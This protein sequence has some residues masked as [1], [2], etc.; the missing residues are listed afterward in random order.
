MSFLVAQ[1]S[2]AFYPDLRSLIFCS[3]GFFYKPPPSPLSPVLLLVFPN[4]KVNCWS[5]QSISDQCSTRFFFSYFQSIHLRAWGYFDTNLLHPLPPTPLPPNANPVERVSLVS[6]VYEV[7]EVRTE[8]GT[9][10][11]VGVFSLVSLVVAPS[12]I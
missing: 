5:L 9:R 7:E 10:Q 1:S 4:L 11:R 3:I 6:F 2:D 12:Q 8:D